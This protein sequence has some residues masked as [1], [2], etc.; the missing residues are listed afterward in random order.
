MYV[1]NLAQTKAK[2]ARV[3]VAQAR[4]E[5]ALALSTEDSMTVMS[6]SV[7][8]RVGLLRVVA[9]LAQNLLYHRMRMIIPYMISFNSCKRMMHA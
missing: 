1:A 4:K 8:C 2:K 5:H 6:V 3:Y 7:M 9:Q